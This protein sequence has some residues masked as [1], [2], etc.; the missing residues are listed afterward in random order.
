MARVPRKGPISVAPDWICEVLSPRT[1]SYDHVTK[2]RF[3]AEIGVSFLW[4]VDPLARL[5]MASKL[6]GG[7]WV[8]LGSW[9]DDQKVRVEP[10]DAM[11]LDLAAWWEGSRTRSARTTSPKRP[12]CRRARAADACR[13]TSRIPEDRRGRCSDART[14]VQR[15]VAQLP[16]RAGC[17]GRRTGAAEDRELGEQL[18]HQVICASAA[19]TI[20]RSGH[21]AANS[22]SSPPASGRARQR[23]LAPRPR[24]HPP[25]AMAARER[26][27]R[28]LSLAGETEKILVL[29][30]RVD[31]TGPGFADTTTHHLLHKEREYSVAGLRLSWKHGHGALYEKWTIG[32]RQLVR[33]RGLAVGDGVAIASVV[34]TD[35]ALYPGTPFVVVARGKVLD[36]GK[37]IAIFLRVACARRLVRRGER[38]SGVPTGDNIELHARDRLVRTGP[39]APKMEVGPHQRHRRASSRVRPKNGTPI[40]V[41][42]AR[43]RRTMGSRVP[44]SQSRRRTS[45]A[46]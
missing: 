12:R 23:A 37:G 18:W 38:L 14:I 17:A 19:C 11:E 31:V 35:G 32:C 27:I 7:R 2:R 8:E 25:R 16:I 24:L 3:Y 30:R 10:F 28:A 9:C 42:N 41:P 36:I 20:E 4:Y 46:R 22:R 34:A 5:L 33:A 39:P 13:S 21:A 15:P 1:R 26:M 43:A 40:G 45:G 44:R 6:E 29:L